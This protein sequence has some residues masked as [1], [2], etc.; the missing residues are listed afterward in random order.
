MTVKAKSSGSSLC[1]VY[2]KENPGVYDVFFVMVGS[3]IQPGSPLNVH[4]GGIVKFTI[5]SNAVSN[6]NF[7]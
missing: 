4:A 2:L 7:A 3:L 1:V 6:S 5:S